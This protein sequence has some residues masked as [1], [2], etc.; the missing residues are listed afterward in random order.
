LTGKRLGRRLTE[1]VNGGGDAARIRARETALRGRDG[2][3]AMGFA[4]GCSEWGR[5]REKGA[6][7]RQHRPA[8][9]L[10]GAGDAGGWWGSGNRADVWRK[11][12]TSKGGPYQPAGG[13]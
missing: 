8:P 9:F 11:R 3:T 12:G 10:E 2:R 6:E 5:R 4:A 1:R 13:A 7:A